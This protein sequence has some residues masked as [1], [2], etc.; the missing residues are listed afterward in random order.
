MPIFNLGALNTSA[1]VAPDVYI[2]KIPP[3]TRFINGVPTDILG[4]VGVGSWGPVNSA[5]LAVGD[6]FGTVNNRKYDLATAISISSQIGAS[7]VRAVR[8]TDGTDAAAAVNVIDVAGTPV[9]GLVLTAFYT[10]IIGNGLSY[11]VATG[12]KPTTFKL[13]INR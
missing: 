3:Q 4:L 1:L 13:T 11:A 7:N 5:V 9:T 10:G 6:T 8:V 2:Q 12:T